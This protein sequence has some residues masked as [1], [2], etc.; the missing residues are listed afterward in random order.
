MAR[1]A[2]AGAA[3]ESRL[4]KAAMRIRKARFRGSP[5]TMSAA[6]FSRKDRHGSPAAND[7]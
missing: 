4:G 2:Q 7:R 1:V 5:L 3:A 6:K